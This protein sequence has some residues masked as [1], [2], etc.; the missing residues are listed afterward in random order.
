MSNHT[1][2]SPALQI[3]LTPTNVVLPEGH[4]IQQFCV[5][6]LDEHISSAFDSYRIRL[7]VTVEDG[8]AGT[9]TQGHAKGRFGG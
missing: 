2:V 9:N 4:G 7:D 8:S 1:T 3:E 5:R 6:V